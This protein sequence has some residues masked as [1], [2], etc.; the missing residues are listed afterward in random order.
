MNT[1]SFHHDTVT[2][3][4]WVFMVLVFSLVF[5]SGILFSVGKE[6]RHA[7]DIKNTYKNEFN[8]RFH[9]LQ[10]QV[11]SDSVECAVN[12]ALWLRHIKRER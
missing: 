4:T 11:S 2:I 9:A 7:I 6:L 10:I 1:H 3:P 5:V 8:E 12:R